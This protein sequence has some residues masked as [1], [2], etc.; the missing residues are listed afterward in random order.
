[1]FIGIGVW[2]LLAILCG[3]YAKGRGLSWAKFF[4]ISLLITPLI[5][6]IWCYI[7]PEDIEKV[8][9]TKVATK[10]NKRCPHCDELVR[11]KANKCKHC[12]SDLTGSKYEAGSEVCSKCNEP[13]ASKVFKKCLKCGNMF[14][15]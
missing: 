15:D 9:Y 10:Q 3:R 4:W 6:F 14:K 2:I 8:E 7:T 12:G 5:G 1:M 13:R 11:V